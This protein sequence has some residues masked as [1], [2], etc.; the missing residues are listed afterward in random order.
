MWTFPEVCTRGW[1]ITSPSGAYSSRQLSA[2]SLLWSLRNPWG[3]DAEKFFRDNGCRILLAN[4]SRNKKQKQKDGESRL[5]CNLSAAFSPWKLW[6]TLYIRPPNKT[7]VITI[8]K[9][10]T[11]KGFLERIEGK[12][13]VSAIG[14]VQFWWRHKNWDISMTQVCCS[15]LISTYRV[16]LHSTNYQETNSLMGKSEP[17][18]LLPE[19]LH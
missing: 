14:W 13:K 5:Y 15:L 1:L 17:I 8:T 16:P 7:K 6:K 9:V 3:E 4:F 12:K 18:T 11:S 2:S 10:I 19:S